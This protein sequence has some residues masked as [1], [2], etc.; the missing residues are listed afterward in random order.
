MQQLLKEIRN[1]T[2]CQPHLDL[3]AN[4][5]ISANKNSKILL[6]S[7]APGRIAHLKSKAWD[8]PSGKVLRKWLNVD[9]T[10][11]Y[12]A[13]NFAI[14]PTGQSGNVFSEYYKDQAQKY[15]DGEFVKMKLNQTEIEKSENVLILK[16][17]N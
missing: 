14:L 5:I 16:P 2:L 7:Q 3:G 8:D 15:L 10:T 4:P 1:C 12:N 17:K 11:F 9:E 6:I 13:D